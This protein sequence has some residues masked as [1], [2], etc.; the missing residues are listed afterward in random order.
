MNET[1]TS[2]EKNFE[3]KVDFFSISLIIE[4]LV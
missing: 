2:L 3:W 4:K 1:K